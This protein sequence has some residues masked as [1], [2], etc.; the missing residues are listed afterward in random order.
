M[1]RAR[2]ASAYV[3]QACAATH[4]RWEGQCRGCGAWNSLVE[5]L[6]RPAVRRPAGSDGARSSGLARVVE[7]RPLGSLDVA[8]TVRLPTGVA[9][10]DRLLGGGLVPG[11]LLLLGGEPG[12]GKSTLVLQIAGALAAGSAVSG[13]GRTSGHGVARRDPGAGCSTRVPRNRRHSSTCAPPASA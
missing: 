7:P 13:P 6:V 12:I 2:A 3:C 10:V 4:P 1:A 9:E 8:A 11:S 5:T